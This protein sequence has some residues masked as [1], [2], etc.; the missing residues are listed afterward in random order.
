MQ[1][2]ILEAIKARPCVRAYKVPEP[3]KILI[4]V[5]SCNRW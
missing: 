5:Y 4:W 1:Q 2:N 3:A